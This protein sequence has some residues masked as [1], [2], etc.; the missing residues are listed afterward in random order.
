M[1]VFL[2]SNLQNF[3]T[4]YLPNSP[5]LI[6]MAISN[7][8]TRLNGNKINFTIR[9]MKKK[10]IILSSCTYLVLILLFSFSLYFAFIHAKK[11]RILKRYFHN[12][13]SICLRRF[14]ILKTIQIRAPNLSPCYF[15][16]L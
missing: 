12:R 8:S 16:P 13:D 4:S 7:L 14:I 3:L 11:K 5:L 10:I 6:P 2:I 9:N 15:V 1:S